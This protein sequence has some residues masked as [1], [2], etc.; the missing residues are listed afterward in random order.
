MQDQR[1]QGPG[2]A[3]SCWSTWQFSKYTKFLPILHHGNCSHSSR[4]H[5]ILRVWWRQG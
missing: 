4:P 2:R 1:G 5:Q 3:S